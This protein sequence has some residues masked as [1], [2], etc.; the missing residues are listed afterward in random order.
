MYKVTG[1]NYWKE[2][3]TV[4]HACFISLIIGICQ[5]CERSLHQ[6]I[7]HHRRTELS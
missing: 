3:N 1:S 6:R 4:G 7:K 2:E 5:G